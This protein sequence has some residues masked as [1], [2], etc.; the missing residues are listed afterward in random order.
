MKHIRR[1]GRL[2]RPAQT[3]GLCTD[4]TSDLQARFCFVLSF[5]SQVF[6]PLVQPLIAIK[7]APTPTPPATEE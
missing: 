6:V 5:F 3:D 4:I 7:A 2:P 1:M